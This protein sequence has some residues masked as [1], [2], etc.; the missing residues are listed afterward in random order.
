MLTKKQLIVLFIILISLVGGNI[1]SGETYFTSDM[2][3]RVSHQ[4]KLEP[5][6]IN[7]QLSNSQFFVL[8]QKEYKELNILLKSYVHDTLTN[9]EAKYKRKIKAILDESIKEL[10]KNKI[11]SDGLPKISD[12]S[13]QTVKNRTGY[14]SYVKVNME[15]L[16]GQD[17]ELG[18]LIAGLKL[19]ALRHSVKL[20]DT[21]KIE[22]ISPNWIITSSSGDCIESGPGTLPVPPK[23]KISD[24]TYQMRCAEAGEVAGLYNFYDPSK[25]KKSLKAPAISKNTHVY[26]LDTIPPARQLQIAY[27]NWYKS[28]KLLADLLSGISLDLLEYDGVDKITLE[29][30]NLNYYSSSIE[31]ELAFENVSAAQDTIYSYNLS[32]HGLF[33]AGIINTIDPDANIHLYEV[34]NNNG[35]GTL[36][37]LIWGMIKIGMLS[38]KNSVYTKYEYYK[39]KGL[40]RFNSIVNCSLTTK[41]FFPRT[42][43]FGPLL[44]DKKEDQ[45]LYYVFREP[46]FMDAMD[47]VENFKSDLSS[48]SQ[49]S[50]IFGAAGNDSDLIGT[51]QTAFPAGSSE[52]V[53]IGALTKNMHK[54]DYSHK[55]DNPVWDG[56][57]AYGG[58]LDT[59]DVA[60]PDLDIRKACNL[61]GILS[62]YTAGVYPSTDYMPVNTSGWARWAGTSFATAVASGI[63]S[64][65]LS[66]GITLAPVQII[67]DSLMEK[68]AIDYQIIPIVQGY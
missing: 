23:D 38:I 13:I 62:V 55:A 61:K 14:S 9:D 5:S 20:Q 46:L 37:N 42:L 53:G 17:L 65:L 18:I 52:V 66:T 54:A 36:D 11:L 39:Q 56:L 2:I 6:E 19:K 30:L 7:R 26:I 35:I 41:I 67:R 33:I 31:N 47:T 63:T 64:R 4:K 25:I 68:I 60:I 58:N 45:V 12:K 59:A 29:N 43:D 1:L 51:K 48:L 40:E 32:D 24:E 22:G 10:E 15:K 3:I 34:L 50:I 44:D 57:M 16:S 28:N 49:F 27:K 21:L 8:K